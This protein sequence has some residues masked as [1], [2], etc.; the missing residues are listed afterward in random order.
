MLQ[1]G[2]IVAAKLLICFC[3]NVPTSRALLKSTKVLVWMMVVI[4]ERA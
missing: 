2:G 1:L 3:G 4:A